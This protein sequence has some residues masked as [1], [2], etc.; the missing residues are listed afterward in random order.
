MLVIE[1]IEVVS[2]VEVIVGL[3]EVVS[4]VDVRI[5]FV[6]VVLAKQKK[7]QHVFVENFVD[8][9]TSCACSDSRRCFCCHGSCCSF[10]NRKEDF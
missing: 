5:E 2:V 4:V 8:K 7:N 10:W 6:E 1:L 9:R 3:I